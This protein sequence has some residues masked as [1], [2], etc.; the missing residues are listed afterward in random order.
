[1]RK[2]SFIIISTLIIVFLTG[3]YFIYKQ[4][5]KTHKKEFKA[6]I[7][8]KFAKTTQLS[9]NPSE[10][11]SDNSRIKWLDEN[12]EVILD[13]ILYDIVS[14]KN[15]GVSVKLTVVND[16]EEKALIDIYSEQFDDVYTSKTSKNKNQLANDF[17]SLKYLTSNP[18]TFLLN[19]TF[20]SY[21]Q[22]NKI[23]LPVGY[24]LLHT[25][26]PDLV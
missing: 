13:N 5:T 10:L 7:R 2:A 23:N 22:N 3:N 25:P 9:I 11:Y 24:T 6:Y 8:S 14:I 20:I 16:K 1:M 12:K 26:P 17:F 21:F 19:S 15:N 18:S 4:I